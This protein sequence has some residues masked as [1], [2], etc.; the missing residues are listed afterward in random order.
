MIRRALVVVVAVASLGVGVMSPAWAGQG[1]PAR[2][3]PGSPTRAAGATL[4]R[5]P[6][7]S[8]RGRRRVRRSTRTARPGPCTRESSPRTLTTRTPSASTTSPATKRRITSSARPLVIDARAERPG[9]LRARLQRPSPWRCYL[10]RAWTPDRWRGISRSNAR[11]PASRCS[12]SSTT[13]PWLER[14]CWSWAAK[15][16]PRIWW[17]RHSRGRGI[18]GIASGPW[19]RPPVTCTGPR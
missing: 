16:K 5:T 15:R 14:W 17:R 13:R 11:R 19:P 9:R 2:P 6:P 1:T 12:S 4:P 10:S 7:H 8:S 18:D 3:G